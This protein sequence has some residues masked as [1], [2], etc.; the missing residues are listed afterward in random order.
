[1]N[2]KPPITTKQIWFGI[3][4]VIL[5]IGGF[6]LAD[7]F[8]GWKKNKIT[9]EEIGQKIDNIQKVLTPYEAK[10]NLNKLIVIQNFE[11]TVIK[12]TPN[13]SFTKTLITKGSF[14][15]GYL[16]IKASVNG[17]AMDKL[18]DIYVKISGNVNG[19]YQEAGGHLIAHK[20][21]SVPKSDTH[22]E[23]LFELSDIKYKESYLKSDIEVISGDWLTLL[24][25]DKSKMVIGFSST[26]QI[27]KIE[28]FSIYYQCV[29]GNNCS[30]SAN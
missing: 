12:T 1:M 10:D 11:N 17:K 30:I 19:K 2:P 21:L 24:N 8:L 7:L 18:G 28:E 4:L 13:K 26:E 3:F 5:F 9:N 27:G 20:G 23:I 14:S 25:S 6:I 16:Y 22:T 29:E 15:S